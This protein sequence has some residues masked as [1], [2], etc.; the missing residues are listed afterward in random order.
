VSRLNK[1]QIIATWSWLVLTV[2]IEVAASPYLSS[3]AW[4]ARGAV[5][6]IIAISA[7]IP[8]MLFYMGLWEE[9]LSVKMFV[10][11]SLFFCIDLVL[12]WSASSVH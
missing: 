1:N 11:V 5:E 9:H 3:A 10:L 2:L 8:L 12:I 7:V 6:S 4:E